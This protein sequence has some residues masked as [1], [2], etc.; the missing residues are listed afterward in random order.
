MNIVNDYKET[1]HQLQQQPPQLQQ[2]PQ[3]PQQTTNPNINNDR[4]EEMIKQMMKK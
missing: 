2:Q 4:L 3:Q 1:L